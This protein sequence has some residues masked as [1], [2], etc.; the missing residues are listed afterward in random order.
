MFAMPLLLLNRNFNI[1]TI[2]ENQRIQKEI[3]YKSTLS[4]EI[5]DIEK[6][7]LSII[8]SNQYVLYEVLDT[9]DM[10]N[11]LKANKD[12]CMFL[13]I[14]VGGGYQEYH[15]V[16]N[17]LLN[18]YFKNNNLIYELDK[19]PSNDERVEGLIHINNVCLLWSHLYDKE[20][21][22]RHK[23][24][25]EMLNRSAVNSLFDYSSIICY[26]FRISYKK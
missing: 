5:S 16:V 9:L 19:I 18:K 25:N 22:S 20:K 21:I 12:K 1:S 7:F 11:Q 2:M 23:L 14:T 13:N 24:I 17:V 4:A 26:S 8:E 15:V 3:E 6:E 10:I